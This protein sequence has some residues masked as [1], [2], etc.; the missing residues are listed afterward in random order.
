MVW[1]RN[2]T[3]FFNTAVSAFQ[4]PTEDSLSETLVRLMPQ[5]LQASPDCG[6]LLALPFMDDE[7]GLQVTSGPST[8][9]VLG[10]TPDNATAGNIIHAALVSTMMNLRAG[11]QI[12][13]DQGV[14]ELQQIVLSG[15]LVK[16]PAM[17][18][19]VANVFDCP[20]R[21]LAAADEGSSWGATVMAAY[22]HYVL[23]TTTTSS[24]SSDAVLAW[25]TFLQQTAHQRPTPTVFNPQP[26]AV[27]AYQRI[28]VKHEKLRALEGAL[29]D[30]QRCEE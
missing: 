1:L 13:M 16:T 4:L 18:Q 14:V 26:N 12:L 5:V 3:T 27:R 15:G 25:P 7:P 8:A 28:Y 6:G 17:G 21:L 19:V 11:V 2:G 24:S 29:R 30:L 22:R 23:T 20:V 10:W 9:V